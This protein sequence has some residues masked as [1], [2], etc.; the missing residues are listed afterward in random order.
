MQRSC[1]SDQHHDHNDLFTA[2]TTEAGG[3]PYT[4]P[5]PYI[6]LKAV[7]TI[8]P[9]V[10][11]EVDLVNLALELED[12]AG[13][14]YQVWVPLFSTPSCARPSSR[15]G[16]LSAATRSSSRGCIPEEELF[17]SPFG[18]VTLAVGPASYV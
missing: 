7:D 4:E 14:S 17:P 5:N 12:T 15:S 13:G 1:S 6:Q 2:A 10:K 16:P 3:E 9:S 8:L 11:K 18:N